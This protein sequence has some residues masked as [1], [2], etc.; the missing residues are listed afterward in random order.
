MVAYANDV[1]TVIRT[2]LR[3]N[4]Y[5]AIL[6]GLQINEK[7]TKCMTRRQ[8]NRRRNGSGQKLNYGEKT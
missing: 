1:G 7:Q 4:K 5:L 2:L 3:S 6:I 8:N